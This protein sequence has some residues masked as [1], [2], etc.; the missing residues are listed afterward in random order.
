[1]RGF[2]RPMMA[3]AMIALSA[4][5]GNVAVKNDVT[6]LE[7]VQVQ[8]KGKGRGKALAKNWR[9]RNKY[10]G[11]DLRDIRMRNGV[12]WVKNPVARENMTR[13]FSLWYDKKFG[14]KPIESA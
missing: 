5:A 12:G 6:P 1:M 8:R 13:M 9:D 10:S 4:P 2:F 14:D 3:A 7:E 11:A